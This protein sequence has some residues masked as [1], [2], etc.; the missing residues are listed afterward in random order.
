MK[1]Q[2]DMTVPYVPRDFRAL[3]EESARDYGEREAYI[4][5]T[6]REKGDESAEYRHVTFNEFKKDAK[7]LGTALLDLFPRG[8]HI[9]VMGESRYE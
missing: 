6:K 2:F 5:K 3:I 4:I 1:K 7:V 9:A 8:S